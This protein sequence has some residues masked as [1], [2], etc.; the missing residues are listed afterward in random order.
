V[1]CCR[2]CNWMKNTHP[3]EDWIDHMAKILRHRGF[4]VVSGNV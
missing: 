1:P 2:K 3:V 4:A